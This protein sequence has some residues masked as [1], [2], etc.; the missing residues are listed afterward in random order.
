MH[1]CHWPGCE[2]EVPPAIWGCKPHWLKLP[3]KLRDAIWRTYRPGQEITKIPSEAYIKA[4]RD[5]RN[6]ILDNANHPLIRGTNVIYENSR[7]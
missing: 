3:Q 1:R 4:A 6:W 7:R 2:R 5:A